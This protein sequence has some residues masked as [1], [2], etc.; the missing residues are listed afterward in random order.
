MEEYFLV[1][2]IVGFH[3]S[4]GSLKV[5]LITDFPENFKKQKYFYVEFSGEKKKIFSEKI[6]LNK[7]GCVINFKD[8]SSNERSELLIGKEVFIDSSQLMK[9][10]K[11]QFFHHELVGSEVYQNSEQIGK[12]K[13]ILSMHVHDVFVIE[14]SGKDDLLVPFVKEFFN[15]FH[16]DE[17]K[18]FL[19]TPAGFFED[20]I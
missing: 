3:A 10:E 20:V 8:F 19:K 12:L 18:I 5:Q 6:V 7:N 11:N 13:E 15:S 9:L 1:A 17:K 14:R 4:D 2:R 16:K